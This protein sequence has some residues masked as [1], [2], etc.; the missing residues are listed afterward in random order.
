MTLSIRIATPQGLVFCSDSL[1][2]WPERVKQWESGPLDDPEIVERSFIK[3]TKPNVNKIMQLSDFPIA[4]S[5]A[6]YG[7]FLSSKSYL[8]NEDSVTLPF[9]TYKSVV[10]EVL[11][12]IFE[13]SPGWVG[14]VGRCAS[15]AICCGTVAHNVDTVAREEEGWGL[16][17]LGGGFEETS[18]QPSV[19]HARLKYGGEHSGDQL[20]D[21]TTMMKAITHSFLLKAFSCLPNHVESED[22]FES[23]CENDMESCVE[24]GMRRF[25]LY[26]AHYNVPTEN[27]D[28]WASVSLGIMQRACFLLGRLINKIELGGLNEFSFEDAIEEMWK[29]KQDEYYVPEFDECTSKVFSRGKD[30]YAY[31]EKKPEYLSEL[32]SLIFDGKEL[33]E[34]IEELDELEDKETERFPFLLAP[35]EAEWEEH[36]WDHGHVFA[37][38][39]SAELRQVWY[40]GRVNALFTLVRKYTFWACFTDLIFLD[41]SGQ[42]NQ[43]FHVNYFTERYGLE[44]T[45]QGSIVERITQGLSKGTSDSI[46][47]QIYR[48]NRDALMQ[49]GELISSKLGNIAPSRDGSFRRG[50]WHGMLMGGPFD[51]GVPFEAEFRP[52][53]EFEWATDPDPDDFIALWKANGESFMMIASPDPDV[54]DYSETVFIF[55]SYGGIEETEEG[56]PM[57]RITFVGSLDDMGFFGRSEEGFTLAMSYGT[58]SEGP[59]QPAYI[60][61]SSVSEVLDSLSKVDLELTPWDIQWETLPLSTSIEIA[62]FLMESTIKN[63]MFQG[64]IPTV[65]G[66]IRTLTIT[67]DG[68]FKEYLNG[69]ER[70]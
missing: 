45:G 56:G 1:V 37:S 62:H 23:F 26:F 49:V 10:D 6:G 24:S 29:L 16:E 68:K 52:A 46:H 7:A 47:H 48:Q 33:V 51:E 12:R 58:L 36:G 34:K 40:P 4:I 19:F 9:E 70:P 27:F 59:T 20:G 28:G 69:E 8:G 39:L 66:D 60:V 54:S 38:R 22:W 3:D 32:K 35:T 41:K 57:R 44:Y 13:E 63:Q 67:P 31:L 15:F 5:T 43:S 11:S 14:E 50:N 2:S 55:L 30:D 18:I 21:M 25:S 64:Q 65:G 61:R 53:G 17:L 42:D